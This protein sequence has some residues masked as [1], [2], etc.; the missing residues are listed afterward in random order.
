[1]LVV[2]VLSANKCDRC[3]ISHSFVSFTFWNEK[4]KRKKKSSSWLHPQEKINNPFF[5]NFTSNTSVFVIIL[6]MRYTLLLELPLS[7]PLHRLHT[8]R[9]QPSWW[10]WYPLFCLSNCQSVSTLSITF[11]VEFSLL[12]SLPSW[13][14]LSNPLQT[15]PLRPSDLS[16]SSPPLSPFSFLFFFIFSWPRPDLHLFCSGSHSSRSSPSAPL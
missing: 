15:T 8:S 9:R 7:K 11:T 6:I 2:S 13:P 14:R 4:K 16:S 12:S 5:K 1:M 10:L 3:H